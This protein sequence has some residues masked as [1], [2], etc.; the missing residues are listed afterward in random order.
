[1]SCRFNK[2][3]IIQ[4]FISC[5]CDLSL[6]SFRYGEK[7]LKEIFDTLSFAELTKITDNYVNELISK[8]KIYDVSLFDYRFIFQNTCDKLIDLLFRYEAEGYIEKVIFPTES[9]EMSKLINHL[10]YINYKDNIESIIVKK[11]YGYE[12]NRLGFIPMLYYSN[13]HES[14]SKMMNLFINIYCKKYGIFIKEIVEKIIDFDNNYKIGFAQ[15]IR[16][17]YLENENQDFVCGI[18]NYYKKRK[19]IDEYL[20]N[21]DIIKK[22]NLITY[23]FYSNTPEVSLVFLNCDPTNFKNIQ[24]IYNADKNLFIVENNNND[25]ARKEFKLIEKALSYFE[26]QIRNFTKK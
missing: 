11:Y 13:Y 19:Q 4:L 10:F 25:K 6:V 17:A 22:Y 24:L 18:L 21:L 9:D 7:K 14:Y 15:R 23:N 3:K 1:M 2:T 8:N 5:K 12:E 20:L 16:E 26:K